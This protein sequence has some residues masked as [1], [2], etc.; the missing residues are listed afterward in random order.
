M[1]FCGKCGSEMQ[2]DMHFCQKCGTKQAGASSRE[3]ANSLSGKIDELKK[4]NLIFDRSRITWEYIASIGESKAEEITHSEA[5]LC[6]EMGNL[7]EIILSDSAIT[8]QTRDEV[9]THLLETAYD[10]CDAARAML[11]DGDP[12]MKQASMHFSEGKATGSVINFRERRYLDMI[13]YFAGRAEGGDP[14]TKRDVFD[15]YDSLQKEDIPYRMVSM[16]GLLCAAVLKSKLDPEIIQQNGAHRAATIRLADA[17]DAAMGALSD[18]IDSFYKIEPKRGNGS[19]GITKCIIDEFN[20]GGVSGSPDGGFI[21]VI[22]AP[23]EEYMDMN[24]ELYRTVVSGLSSED[25]AELTTDGWSKCFCNIASSTGGSEY[26]EMAFGRMRALGLQ[27]N[28]HANDQCY[29]LYHTPDNRNTGGCY[30]ATAVYGSYDCPQVWTLRR[31]RDYALARTWY[32]RVFI[33]SYYLIS[34]FLVKRFGHKE[35]LKAMCRRKLDR[36]VDKLQYAGFL[37]A[38]YEDRT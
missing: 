34:P 29:G 25:R 10:L 5:N 24:W 28:E 15:F 12:L 2:D 1:Q 31:Y 22:V 35:W 9:Y 16:C 37:S 13:A 8:I 19:L 30:V 11:F 32:G 36:M 21:E 6:D 18:R 14:N 4:Y 17:F 7:A 33:K 20:A 26:A 3:E 23:D 27:P 38:P